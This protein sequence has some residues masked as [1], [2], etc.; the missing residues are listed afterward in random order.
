MTLYQ[1]I[2]P[3]LRTESPKTAAEAEGKT[4][5]IGAALRTSLR[6]G[7]ITDGEYKQVLVR[8][9][10]Y[11]QSH[12]LDPESGTVNEVAANNG[13]WMLLDKHDRNRKMQSYRHTLL[14]FWCNLVEGQGH[15]TC[16]GR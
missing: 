16:E 1:R 15:K 6:L 14:G 9:K 3:F 13:W 11:L 7:A 12:N 10:A 5:F 2:G 8:V 4:A